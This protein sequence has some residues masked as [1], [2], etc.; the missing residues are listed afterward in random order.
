MAP[1]NFLVKRSLSKISENAVATYIHVSN[2]S[3]PECKE[4]GELV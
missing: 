1:K 4:I 2:D 3:S